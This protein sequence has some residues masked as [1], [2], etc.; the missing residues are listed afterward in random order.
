MISTGRLDVALVS[1]LDALS[2]GDVE[3]L[4]DLCLSVTGDA[5]LA[6]LLHREPLERL[7]R[8]ASI[9]GDQRA[10]ALLALVFQHQG[11]PLPS[12]HA[13]QPVLSRMLDASEAA[14]I[15]GPLASEEELP[16]GCLALDLSAA[17]EA[18]AGLP[19]VD[20]VWV[21]RKSVTDPDLSFYFKSSLRYGLSMLDNL[22]RES[23]A[24]L[25]LDPETLRARFDRHYS[26]VLRKRERA[27]LEDLAR[28]VAEAGL[29][30][31][32]SLPPFRV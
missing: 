24:A 3:L 5:G 17:W 13:Q 9:P 2:L 8:V 32:P 27:S 26:Y 1:S 16:S 12:V 14:L 18:F 31:A 15:A 30:K 11:L 28:E 4:P 25:G 6:L 20:S 10:M 21:V 29:V 7:R 19:W 22:V 23:A